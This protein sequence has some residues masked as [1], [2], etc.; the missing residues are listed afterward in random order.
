MAMAGELTAKRIAVVATDGFEQSEL[1]E[2]RNA[3]RQAGATVEV[4]SPKRGRIQGMK[5]D[6]KGDQ[7]AVDRMIDEAK[8]EDYDGLVL[9]GGVANPDGLRTDRG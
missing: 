9:P 2:P 7:V 4:V 5:H 8:P 3:L 1:I 6:E